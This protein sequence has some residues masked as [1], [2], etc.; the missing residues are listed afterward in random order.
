LR[1][2]DAYCAQS[3]ERV[4]HRRLL[5]GLTRTKAFELKSEL[6]RDTSGSF[7]VT[8]RAPRGSTHRETQ[9]VWASL[10]HEV[11]SKRQTVPRP[12]RQCSLSC[13]D[14]V[15]ESLL[16]LPRRIHQSRPFVRPLL[17]QVIRGLKIHP[18]LRGRSERARELP[19]GVR[20]DAA[21]SVHKLVHPLHGNLHVLGQTELRDPHGL[22]KLLEK[23]LAGVGRGAVL[24]DHVSC[25]SVIVRQRD[26]VRSI[27]PAKHDAPLLV[28]PDGVLPRK[29]ARE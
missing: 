28:H 24:R 4:P 3:L 13:L 6:L 7:V 29:I 15:L 22:K 17:T 19:R 26:F 18:E 25:S 11:H 20:G 2:R 8:R 27:R 1:W 10:S 16:E 14:D 23:N 12:R 21:L 5:E 9:L